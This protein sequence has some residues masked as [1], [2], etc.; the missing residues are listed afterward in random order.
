[1][2]NI[3]MF[4][5]VLII[6]NCVVSCSPVS[7]IDKSS[8]SEPVVMPTKTPYPTPLPPT[9]TATW[10]VPATP[11]V[12]D[13]SKTLTVLP[14]ENKELIKNPGKGWV[15]YFP[16][17]DRSEEIW[18]VVSVC[19]SRLNWVWVEPTE[20]EYYWPAIDES[21][22]ECVKHGGKFAFGI[23]VTN[24]QTG[25]TEVTPDW[26]FE[27]GAK[28]EIFQYDTSRDPIKSV[29]WND[30]VY[31][32]KMQNLINALAERYDGSSDIAYID[33]RNCGMWGEW[34][35]FGCSELSD[36]D[37]TVLIDQWSVFKKTS[38]IV[39]TNFDFSEIQAKYGADQYHFGI[40]SD[41]SEFRRNAAAYAYDK[42][43]AV[44][45]WGN[46]Y[47]LIKACQGWS[48]VCWTPDILADYM[49]RTK[50]SYDNLGQ[51]G[52]DSD[53]FLAENKDLVYDW[54][55]RMGYW[56]KLTSVTYPLN[57][58]NGNQEKLIFN[59]RNDGVAP[60]YVN[61][62]STFV[63]LALLDSSGLVLAVSD[64][65]EGVNPYDWKPDTIETVEVD[66]SFPETSDAVYLAI[67]LFSSEELL[68]PDIKFGNSG[69]L[70]NNWFPIHGDVSQ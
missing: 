36:K 30:P 37:K 28:S 6:A 2:K 59:V 64:P 14:Q 42:G 61:Y 40:R 34:H 7:D 60:I 9:P 20:G 65:L 15:L 47:E 69:V 3:S 57:L 66:I 24:D 10:I 26:V 51:W 21:V 17:K 4:I 52:T 55:N 41:S 50:F 53:L 54:G 18:D 48:G 29:V 44:S 1:M 70:Q 12:V 67:G 45:E 13:G 56:F 63:R 5:I 19:Y 49:A 31:L 11:A 32:E 39:P 62:N 46:S 23:M 22:Q 68:E 33:A 16:Y 43:P 8:T 27:A 38:I 25:S 58:A 35:D